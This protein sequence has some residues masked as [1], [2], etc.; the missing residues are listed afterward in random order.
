LNTNTVAVNK[1]SQLFQKIYF[2]NF[3]GTHTKVLKP[4][5]AHLGYRN[6]LMVRGS[7]FKKEKIGGPAIFCAPDINFHKVFLGKLVEAAFL[8]KHQKVRS[9][10]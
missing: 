6:L 3:E 4:L 8:K 5:R 1:V 10:S 2:F 9:C 7:F